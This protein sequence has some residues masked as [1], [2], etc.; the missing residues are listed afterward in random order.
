MSDL[1]DRSLTIATQHAVWASCHGQ[2]PALIFEA[3]AVWL[4]LAAR[5]TWNDVIAELARQWRQLPVAA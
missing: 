2:T 5:P 3:L 1:L 4:P